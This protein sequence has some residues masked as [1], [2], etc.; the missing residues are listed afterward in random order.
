[1]NQR[2][3]IVY[4]FVDDGRCGG[5]LRLKPAGKVKAVAERGLSLGKLY[6]MQTAI[7]VRR[8]TCANANPVM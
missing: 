7:S 6:D 1:M 5:A 3:D 8:T 4:F 2:P